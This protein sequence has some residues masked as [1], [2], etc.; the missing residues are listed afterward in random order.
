MLRGRDDW[1]KLFNSG[2]KVFEMDRSTQASLDPDR[3]VSLDEAVRGAK[4]VVER[5]QG[6]VA[7]EPGPS[8]ARFVVRLPVVG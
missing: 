3:R 4:R 7:Y 1:H 5:H 8:G 2:D 6:T